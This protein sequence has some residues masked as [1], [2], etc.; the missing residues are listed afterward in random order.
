VGADGGRGVGST[1]RRPGKR[2]LMVGA[3]T[4]ACQWWPMGQGGSWHSRGAHGGA[5]WTR[6]WPE[7]SGDDEVLS[8]PGRRRSAA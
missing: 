4:G 5:S 2:G 1:T 8:R 7:A 6:W 3:W